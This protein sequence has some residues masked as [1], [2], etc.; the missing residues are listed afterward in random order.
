MKNY[1]NDFPIFQ[2]NKNLVYLDSAATSQKPKIVLDAMQDYYE[3]Y[4]S[5]V[6]RALYPIAEKATKR[7]E[8]VRGQIAR[9]LHAKDTSE[10]VFVRNATEAINLV[11]YSM[12]H[13]ISSKDIVMATV[14]EHHSNFV[15]WQVLAQRTG[16]KFEVI[17]FD[18]NFDLGFKIYDLRKVKVLAITHVSNVLGVVNP[19]REII[20]KVKKENPNILVLVDAAQSVPHIKID[21]QDLDCDFLVFSGHKIFASTGI[22]V[23]YGKKKLLEKMEP[24]LFGGEMIREVARQKT[25]FAQI[26]YKFEA[27][28]PD[29]AGIISLGAAIEYIKNTGIENIQKYE[30]ELIA[31]GLWQ[32]EKIKGLEIIGPKNPKDR[33]SLISFTI[34][35][36]HPHDMAQILGDTNICIRSGHHCAM[37]LHKRLG[38]SASA[39]I[40]ISVYNN[41]NDIDQFINGL[42]KI[43]KL[44]NNG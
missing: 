18:D 8:Q 40:S 23:L 9:F 43:K 36:I 29:I 7:V 33:S 13:N 5:N 38:I 16:A 20:K 22:G 44:F 15:P 6:H 42:K 30:N 24:F 28:T 3:N 31:Y 2:K 32:M 21:V 19:I 35:G 27:G 37:P 34:E 4:N 14:I 26:P 1:K 11:S 17:D 25:T 12:S 41:E 10:I 39:R